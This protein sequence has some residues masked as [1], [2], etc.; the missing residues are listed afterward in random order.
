MAA[1]IV[2]AALRHA[3]LLATLVAGCT[4]LLLATERLT[5]EPA[6]RARELAEERRLGEV[7]PA[8]AVDRGLTLDALPLAPQYRLGLGLNEPAS[9]RRVRRGDRIVAVIVP[10]VAARGYGGPIHL[11]VGIDRDGLVTGVRVVSERETPGIGDR[12]RAD[13]SDWIRLFTGTSRDAPPAAGWRVRREGGAFD[14][15]TGATVSSRAVV[16][17][18]RRALDYFHDDR[19]RL[20]RAPASAADAGITP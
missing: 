5:R 11:L 17:Q 13:R 18:V 12:I 4:L 6:A 3:L 20:L 19:E 8:L 7:V 15:V 2:S 9:V 1:G 14:A 10:T 16:G